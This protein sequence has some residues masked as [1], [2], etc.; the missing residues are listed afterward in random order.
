VTLWRAASPLVVGHRGGRGEG[1]P[2]ENTIE[3][4]ERAARQGARAVE[5][6][7]RTCAGGV[8]V[9]FHDED[10]AR[11][12]GGRDRRAISRLTSS[13][14]RQIDLGGGAR[15]P[16][17]DEVLTWARERDVAV[18]VEMKHDV[19]S[20]TLLARATEKAIR[21]AK[22][23]VLLSS[24]DPRLLAIM[25]A[26]SPSI[27]RALLTHGGQARWALALEGVILRPPLAQAI[28]LQRTQVEGSAV[29]FWLARGLRVGVWTVNDASEARGLVE[30]GAR[31]IITDAPGRIIDALARPHSQSTAEGAEPAGTG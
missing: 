15:A 13:G 14:L 4:F 18:N 12:T 19:P 23:D 10:L 5:L 30:Q 17:L 26:L 25:G 24:F 28:H 9:V 16:S 29:R 31:T 7:A 22:A 27:P 21:E 3:A 2:P 11:L 20:L 8:A 1:W 6:D